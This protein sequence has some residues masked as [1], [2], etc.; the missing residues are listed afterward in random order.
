VVDLGVETVKEQYLI[1]VRANTELKF[2]VLLVIAA[3]ESILAEFDEFGRE[4]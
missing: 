4:H 2:D 1:N 3:E